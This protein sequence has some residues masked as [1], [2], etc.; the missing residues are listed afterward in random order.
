MQFSEWHVDAE[1]CFPMLEKLDISRCYELM[2]IPDSFGDIASLKFINVRYN[3]QLKESLFKIKEYV[4][5]MTGE[6]ELDVF[7]FPT[8][9]F[10]FRTLYSC[11]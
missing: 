7:F 9:K 10:S 5:E 8:L 1:K 11:G 6:D 3:P 4:E 2:D